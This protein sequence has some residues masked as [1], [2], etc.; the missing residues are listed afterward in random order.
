MKTPFQRDIMFEN[1]TGN[2]R[3][4]FTKCCKYAGKGRA[5]L[6]FLPNQHAGLILKGD[7]LSFYQLLRMKY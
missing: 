5:G 7:K 1:F 4:A 2:I 3:S 6:C